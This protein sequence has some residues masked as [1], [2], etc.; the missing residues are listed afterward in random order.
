MFNK[1][2]ATGTLV[3]AFLLCLV[4]S[5]VVSV[6]AVQLKPV[7]VKNKALDFKSNIL[8]A[9]GIYDASK[10]VEEQFAVITPKVVNLKTG[11]YSD[12]LNPE[13]FEQ[14]EAAK[15]PEL[16][17]E[18]TPAEDVAKLGGRVENYAEVYLVNNPD[19]SLSK[20]ILPIKGYGLWSTMYGFLALEDDLN[21]I[22]GIGFYDHGETP[23]LGGEVDNPSWKQVWEGK[24][25]YSEDGKV[26]L[27]VLKGKASP[28]DEHA[29]D[30][31][32]GATLTSRGVENLIHF[33]MGEQ[34]YAEFLGNLKRGEA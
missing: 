27:D 10:P 6:A 21:T 13:T 5:V 34:G 30:G 24:E 1:D 22:V 29:V 4:C 7:Q 14:S 3:V 28:S 9:A 23:G 20:V 8:Q 25:V 12:E 16:S 18:L 32:S 26:V 31:L 17:R 15:N 33:W 2:S 19:G 11:S